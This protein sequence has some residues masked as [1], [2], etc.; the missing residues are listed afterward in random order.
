MHRLILLL[1]LLANAAH[2]Q[3]RAHEFVVIP[4][5]SSNGILY[6]EDLARTRQINVETPGTGILRIGNG[7]A[8]DH[9]AELHI[10]PLGMG[11]ATPGSVSAL[12]PA[13]GFD[14]VLDVKGPIR[15]QAGIISLETAN[16]TGDPTN[17]SAVLYN[18][19]SFG[20]VISGFKFGIRTG[21]SGST[22]TTEAVIVDENGNTGLGAAPGSYRLDVTG[23][24]NLRQAT[25]VG[26]NTFTG[27]PALVVS[28][29][30]AGDNTHDY[31]PHTALLNATSAYSVLQRF[32]GASALHREGAGV[33]GAVASSSNTN[34]ETNAITAMVVAENCGAAS[35]VVLGITGCP[36]S[37]VTGSVAGSFFA[38]SVVDGG[39][40]WALN[41]HVKDFDQNNPAMHHPSII[42][43]AESDITVAD[44]GTYAAGYT[45]NIEWK[46]GQPLGSVAYRTQSIGTAY[47][48]Y[49]LVSS[50][51]AADTAISIG[52]QPAAL[53]N[54]SQRMQ[55]G[56]AG[57]IGQIYYD[58]TGALVL[59]TDV[60]HNG[61]VL[62]LDATGQ[63][64]LT[65]AAG[66]GGAPVC[67]NAGVLYS[68]GCASGYIKV[69]DYAGVDPT[70]ATDST[71]G[72]A[73]A[74]TAAAGKA[75]WFPA[76]TYLHGK[77]TIPAGTTIFGDGPVSILK[78]NGSIAVGSGWIDVPNSDVRITGL[79]FEGQKTAPSGVRYADVKF[80][81]SGN[82]TNAVFTQ[83]TTIWVHG[84]AS[85]VQ[86]DHNDFTH[87]GAYTVFLDA[88][89]GQITNVSVNDNHLYDIRPMLFGDTGDLN[90]GSWVGGIFWASDNNFYNL[91]NLK[92]VDNV[93]ERVAG[94]GIWGWGSQL[95]YPSKNVNV[96]R[97]RCKDMGLD[98]ILPG[99]Y[100]SGYTETENN[101]TRIGSV[102]T[103]DLT[104]GTYKWYSGSLGSVPAVA[105]DT[106]GRVVNATRTGNTAVGV[107]GGGF[108][109]DGYQG[110]VTGSS[111]D[112][113]DANG[114]GTMGPASSGQNYMYGAQ[115]SNSN[116][117]TIASD[118]VTIDTNVFKMCGGGGVRLFPA[119]N[120]K[121]A[122]NLIIV[123]GTNFYFPIE[124]GN[125]AGT[126]Q[127]AYNNTISNNKIVYTGTIPSYSVYERLSV[128]GTTNR[129][130]TAMEANYVHDND[131]QG[132]P[133]PPF[134]KDPSS[135]STIYGTHITNNGS[136]LITSKYCHTSAS[137]SLTGGVC[138]QVE[139]ISGNAQYKWYNLA[140][141]NFATLAD[142]GTLGITNMTMAGRITNQV[143]HALGTSPGDQYE[144]DYKS[145]TDFSN[146]EE[147][148]TYLYRTSSFPLSHNTAEWRIQRR[149]DGAA[150]MGY[151]A[152]GS[153]YT[154]LSGSGG[155]DFAIDASGNATFYHNLSVFGGFSPVSLL[156][157]G[158]SS[159]NLAIDSTRN[160]ILSA[161][162][163]GTWP[164]QV[165]VIDSSR[166]ILNATSLYMGGQATGNFTID[167]SRNIIA[168]TVTIGT[169]PSQLTVIDSGR[170]IGNIVN[171]NSTG[172]VQTSQYFHTTGGAGVGGLFVNGY[173]V[174]GSAEHNGTLYAPLG[175]I[176][177]QGIQAPGF[178]PTGFFGGTAVN[179]QITNTCGALVAPCYKVGASVFQF[180]DFRGGVMTS[181]HN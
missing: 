89:A 138:T 43:I 145:N 102:S 104:T 152:F 167:G 96:S 60:V 160:G 117:V 30:G 66:S 94:N 101:A 80:T 137:A 52:R 41:P 17:F 24:T 121:V 47:F 53:G 28:S 103:T 174:I 173:R 56:G 48:D 146:V 1:A 115:V 107:N 68:G 112:C 149:V 126:N 147:L 63:V 39:T 70:G 42:T 36:S 40:V 33:F 77:I 23:T 157:N 132:N 134:F 98:C 148:R 141:T 116:D 155:G 119:K 142:N 85:N 127:R 139:M 51:Y 172:Y 161:L 10:G 67:I 162:T 169:Y 164:S 16:P 128:D 55:F 9:S 92:I 26:S 76:G 93:L 83:N 62:K 61:N 108:D 34:Y 8:G 46:N 124:M 129:A 82:P 125:L 97:N 15:A 27:A 99:G 35:S 54:G 130:W 180:A 156:I 79:K 90:Y 131:V 20:P 78:R 151:I 136:G 14:T 59:R 181:L 113:S 177:D 168:N 100:I 2:A 95:N 32:Q 4:S 31:S 11:T 44:T 140:G 38:A 163:I 75:L 49:T 37:S 171:Y 88:T 6:F 106:A 120:S 144:A 176:S 7:T 150:N 109:L 118:G 64:H 5:G 110:A 135:G 86:I 143:S 166:N 111:I 57:G 154:V 91:E 50:D 3:Y 73:S 29:A 178:N 175:M 58:S 71:T 45:T 165:T 22:P 74:L 19:T 179:V 114:I 81:Y 158:T 65:M 159:S 105:F 72:I 18:K 122:H 133:P 87:S 69:T 21:G 153:T 13:V 170:N 25:I 12:T 84:A 123:P